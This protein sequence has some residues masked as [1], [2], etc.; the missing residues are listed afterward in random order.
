VPR[1]AES[2]A[3]RSLTHTPHGDPFTFVYVSG[4]GGIRTRGTLRYTRFPVVHLR[5]LGHLSRRPIGRRTAR[6]D[7]YA[8]ARPQRRSDRLG[9]RKPSL[10]QFIRSAGSCGERG[11]RTPGTREGTP[12]FESGTFNRSVISPPRVLV[13]RPPCCQ[14]RCASWA[15]VL[16][17][18]AL[19]ASPTAHREPRQG[20]KAAT[21]AESG[22]GGAF[23]LLLARCCTSAVAIS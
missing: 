8:R 23:L 9:R 2:F 20:R 3:R 11:I 16:G 17:F 12:D 21:V 18:A 19:T 15:D 22:C 1:A 4:E 7:R 5:P 10:P 14:E 13:D 6:P